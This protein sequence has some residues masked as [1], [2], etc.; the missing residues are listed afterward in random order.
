MM[1]MHRKYFKL[2]AQI[3]TSARMFSVLSVQVKVALFK[4]CCTQL[5]TAHLW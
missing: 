3:N 2:Y 5:C 1:M 4:A